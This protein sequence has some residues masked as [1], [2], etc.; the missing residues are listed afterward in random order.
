MFLKCTKQCWE[1]QALYFDHQSYDL[2]LWVVFD[3]IGFN[4]GTFKW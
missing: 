1:L 2:I 3:I 4:F